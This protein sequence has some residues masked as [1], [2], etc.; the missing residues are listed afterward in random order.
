MRALILC[1]AVLPVLALDVDGN[2]LTL[3]PAEMAHCAQG[4]KLVSNAQ[5]EEFRK[6]V[7]LLVLEIESRPKTCKRGD[8]I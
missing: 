7:E 6:A 3:T 1:F 4:C 2:K 5:L 8:L